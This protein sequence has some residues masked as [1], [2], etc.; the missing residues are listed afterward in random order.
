MTKMLELLLKGFYLAM[1]QQMLLEYCCIKMPPSDPEFLARRH[2]FQPSCRLSL[3]GFFFMSKNNSLN[4]RPP[5][6]IVAVKN[7]DLSVKSFHFAVVAP[8]IPNNTKRLKNKKKSN[9]TK[10]SSPTL[11]IQ[12]ICNNE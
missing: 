4:L 5:K 1:F 2:A 7:E 9:L 11:K 3:H 12:F 6:K 10:S 8:H